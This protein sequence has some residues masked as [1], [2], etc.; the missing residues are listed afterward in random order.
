MKFEVLPSRIDDVNL[1]GRWIKLAAFL[2]LIGEPQ[3]KIKQ[4]LRYLTPGWDVSWTRDDGGNPRLNREYTRLPGT[5]GG[6][7][8]GSGGPLYIDRDFAQRM[9]VRK[10][11]H[12]PLE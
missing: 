1:A 11:S 10:Y 2:R 5:R 12:R 6:G 7:A 9:Y 8:R 4:G 3:A